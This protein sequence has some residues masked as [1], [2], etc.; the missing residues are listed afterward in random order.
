MELTMPEAW[1]N[2]VEFAYFVLTQK[3]HKIK[4]KMKTINKQWNTK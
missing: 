4:Y 1:D 3:Q 2:V